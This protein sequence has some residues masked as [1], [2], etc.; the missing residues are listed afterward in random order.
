[1]ENKRTPTGADTEGSDCPAD[2]VAELSDPQLQIAVEKY[3]EQLELGQAVDR[4]RYVAEYPAIAEPL[5]SCLRGLEFIHLRAPQLHA[6]EATDVLP[7]SDLDTTVATLGDFRL[8]REIGRGG[9]GVVYEAEQ[10]S[11]GRTVAV[12][13]LPFAAILDERHLQRF[14]TEART[15][16]AI[17]HPHIVPVHF[18]GVERGVH[19]YAM[20]LIKGSSL[21]TLLKELC[22]QTFPESQPGPDPPARS[23]V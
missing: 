3:L 11:L 14:K 6:D 16:A 19:F 10:L 7:P 20:Q 22:R 5:D 8:L 12:K 1:M 18:V 2:F 17:S 15:A 13:V 9:M 4:K 21:A 23:S